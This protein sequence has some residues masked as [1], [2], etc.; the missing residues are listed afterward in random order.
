MVRTWRWVWF[1][2]SEVENAQH[3]NYHWNVDVCRRS[4][5]SFSVWKTELCFAAT[6]TSPSTRPTLSLATTSA[7]WCPG[8]GLPWRIS[9]MSPW[10]PSLQ[11]FAL[12]WRVLLLPRCRSLR[13]AVAA[14][15]FGAPRLLFRDPAT[16][17]SRHPVSNP[18]GAY[19][20]RLRCTLSLLNWFHQPTQE[21]ER[22][23]L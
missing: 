14:L 11:G 5:D 6:A 4:K 7:S 8:R 1:K 18:R 12:C 15:L 23:K 13:I 21:T 10:S 17:A 2:C 19:T 9:R 16:S 3:S 20:A 22:R